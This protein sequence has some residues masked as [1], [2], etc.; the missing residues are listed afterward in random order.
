MTA[1]FRTLDDL[2]D[3]SGKTAL[4]RVD[5]NL[6]MQDGDVTDD[7]RIRASAPIRPGAWP[8]CQEPSNPPR[9]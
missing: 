1:Q 3:V 8:P 9:E 6:P 7:T 4:V 5:L 2:S